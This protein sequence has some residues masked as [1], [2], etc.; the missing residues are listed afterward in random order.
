ML[1]MLAPGIPNGTL[2]GIKKGNSYP[3]ILRIS[4]RSLRFRENDRRWK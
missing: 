3:G 4:K 1:R 2:S